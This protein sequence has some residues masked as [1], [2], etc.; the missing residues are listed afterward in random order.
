MAS[1]CIV[2]CGAAGLI[3]AKTL[4]D[5]GLHVQV[6]TRDT[7][8]GGIW[9]AER[10]YPGLSLNNVHGEFRFSCLPMP[11]PKSAETTGG[12]LTG[13]AMQQYMENF[14]ERFL[15][16]RIRYQVEILNISRNTNGN[17]N[18]TVLIKDMV[19][20]GTEEQLVFDKIVLCTGGCSQAYMPPSLSPFV[21]KEMGFTGLVFH[22]SKFKA[23]LENLLSQVQP[24]A[25][26]IVVIGGG[27][28]A[29]DITAYLVNQGRVVTMVFDK[30][31]AFV[32]A[33]IPLPDFIRKSRFLAVLSP[34]IHLRTRLERFLHT[35][36]VGST[37]THAYWKFLARSSLSTFSIPAASPFRNAHSM[38][39][40]IRTN[41]E[42]VGAP[43]GF[44]SLVKEDKI[45]V[46][47]PAR[48]SSFAANGRGVVLDNGRTIEADAVILCTGFN[49]SWGA[50][51][52][53]DTRN[54]L[55]IDR[56]GP[57]LSGDER[58]EWDG[59]LS[60]ANPPVTRSGVTKAAA[61]IY[62]G[63]VPARNLYNRD[64][65]M[66]GSVFTTNN[67]YTFE[68]VAHWI[69][70]Y[71]LG[72]SFLSLPSSVEDALAHTQYT[73]AWLRKRYPEMLSW[74]NESYSSGVTFFNYPQLTDDLLEDMGLPIMR[75]GNWLTWPFKVIDLHEIES[76]HDERFAKR[77]LQDEA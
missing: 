61:S 18:W 32:A 72:D 25:G 70:S 52:D 41:D 37:I 2:G 38:F 27:K 63:I 76:L 36:R 31:D 30:A 56:Q 49:S 13:D 21:A 42:G 39:W 73:A 45:D 34:H 8:P 6:L 22:S 1:V 59:Y 74:V 19:K 65:A 29:Q 35:T 47:A 46:I 60:L 28:S 44:F 54:D 23:N 55:G 43:T 51:F 20:E 4:L 33:P 7:S 64:F 67:G 68:V 57:D 17:G 53:E 5:D 77:L 9:A 71:F 24:K 58:H 75:G 16:G 12:R 69:S 3:T 50:L 48:A 66:S 10:V 26:R 11:P 62:R 15:Q 14:A 40:G